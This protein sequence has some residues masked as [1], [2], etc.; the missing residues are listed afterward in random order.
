MQV[1]NEGGL[2]LL[3]GLEQGDAMLEG[4]D[5]DASEIDVRAF[6]SGAL[7]LA[8]GEGDEDGVFA[9]VEHGLSARLGLQAQSHHEL[10]Q[11][12]SGRRFVGQ[13]ALVVSLV[14]LGF[15]AV[16]M[17]LVKGNLGFGESH[18]L[19]PSRLR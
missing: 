16:E 15:E 9:D 14:E 8:A 11:C 3:E 6:A 5:A 7:R 12:G 17:L 2:A 10:V 19:G 18:L 4:G 13:L 1:T